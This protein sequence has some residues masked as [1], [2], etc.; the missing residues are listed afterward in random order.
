MLH[1]PRCIHCNTT[2]QYYDRNLRV[3][4]EIDTEVRNKLNQLT[5]TPALAR[6]NS[7]QRLVDSKEELTQYMMENTFILKCKTWETN[8]PITFVSENEFEF[9][10]TKGSYEWKAIDKKRIQIK[11]T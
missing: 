8:F 6:Q 2:N 1:Q 3:T 4:Q 10:D 9:V 7:T 5:G 11:R